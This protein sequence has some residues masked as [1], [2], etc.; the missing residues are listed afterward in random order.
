MGIQLPSAGDAG[1]HSHQPGKAGHGARRQ[2]ARLARAVSRPILT[3]WQGFHRYRD[4]LLSPNEDSGGTPRYVAEAKLLIPAPRYPEISRPSSNLVVATLLDEFSA[5]VFHPEFHAIPITPFN[6]EWAISQRPAFLLTESAWRGHRGIW[7]GQMAQ[8]DGPRRPLL[9]VLDAFREAEIPIVF[10]NKED[11]SN[12]DL[13]LGMARL[14][15]HVFTTAEE[16]V[17]TY[18]EML[19]HNQIGVL[20]FAVQPLI[21]NSSWV[22]ERLGKVFFAGTYYRFKHPNRLAQ[23]RNVLSGATE[24]GL[25][26]FNRKPSFGAYKW[27]TEFQPYLRGRL[28]YRQLLVAQKLYKIGL[29]VNSV[30]DSTTMLSRRV[31]ELAASATPVISSPSP[32]ITSFFGNSV[33][34][35]H[36]REE[37]RALAKE[38]LSNEHLRTSMANEAR[39]R[40]Q[41]HTARKRLET[42]R[43]AVGL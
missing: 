10:W 24:L 12:F 15:D 42:L 14:A 8:P 33:A 36:S 40:V 32:A 5:A 4:F 23:M 41:R 20:P 21:H 17:P 22:G 29:N 27:P 43:E 6:V 11:P 25:D 19:G 39:D 13:F 3:A 2:I 1:E 38:L 26:I 31:L 30:E 34:Q 37:A 7:R 28:G 9:R 16:L 18:R 35:V